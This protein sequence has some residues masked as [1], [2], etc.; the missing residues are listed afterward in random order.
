MAIERQVGSGGP[1]EEPD[2]LKVYMD[3]MWKRIPDFARRAA[4]VPPGSI[5]SVEW[6]SVVGKYW[7]RARTEQG[8]NVDEMASK[9]GMDPDELRLF[10]YGI[11]TQREVTGDLPER[12]AQALGQ[13]DLYPRFQREFLEDE[14][15][16]YGDPEDI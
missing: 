8:V 2:H 1:G 13:P 7:L 11:G 14:S 15:R 10:E 12:Y 4:V 5:G 3:K 6:L 9:L 16:M